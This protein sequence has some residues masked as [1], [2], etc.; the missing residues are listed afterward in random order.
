M[1]EGPVGRERKAQCASN[2]RYM[3]ILFKGFK[4]TKCYL[5]VKEAYRRLLK[6][7]ILC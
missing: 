3:L 5:A 2:E 7:G 4:E 6:P 1:S